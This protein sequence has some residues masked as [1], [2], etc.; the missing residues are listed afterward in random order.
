MPLTNRVRGPY[1]KLRI[2]VFLLGFL[3]KE[4]S[5]RAIHRMGKKTRFH[6]GARDDEMS[7]YRYLL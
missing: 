4:Q 7:S 3:A 2:E 1:Y 6:N 5:T